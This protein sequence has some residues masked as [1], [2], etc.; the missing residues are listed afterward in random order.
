MNALHCSEDEL[1]SL[2]DVRE[3]TS[4]CKTDGDEPQRGDD[5]AT[6]TARINEEVYRQDDASK[7]VADPC[8][9]LVS[10]RPAASLTP[11]SF[12]RCLQPFSHFISTSAARHMPT[13][14]TCPSSAV[15]KRFR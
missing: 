4:R 2:D 12:G 6:G 11:L 15:F 3:I 13:A 7:T 5:R 14:F 8:M 10:Q 1:Q 9:M